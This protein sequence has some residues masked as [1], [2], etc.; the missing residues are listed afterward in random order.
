MCRNLGLAAMR[1]NPNRNRFSFGTPVKR[2]LW[3]WALVAFA[4]IMA[5]L[6]GWIAGALFMA[7]W[8]LKTRRPH[9]D[10][11]ADD[12]GDGMAGLDSSRY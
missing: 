8:A 5:A 2:Q 12:L 11:L 9:N 10:A 1:H 3:A 7:A 6:W 4:P